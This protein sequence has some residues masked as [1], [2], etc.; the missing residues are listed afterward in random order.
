MIA[1]SAFINSFYVGINIESIL[2]GESSDAY[3]EVAQTHRSARAGIELLLYFKTIRILLSNRG[4]HKKL[5]LFYALFS[6]MM[7]FLITVW[8]ATQAL[9]GQNM[10]LDPDFPGGPDAYWRANIGVWYMG[11]G[12]VAVIVL[13]LM[14]D[15][16]MV[17]H[18]RGC[19]NYAH[20]VCS[21]STAVGLYGIAIVSLSYSSFCGWLPLV[22]IIYTLLPCG[23][24][25]F[26]PCPSFGS[27]SR[28][29]HQFTRW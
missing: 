13:Q 8:V 26:I 28:M 3:H 29:G 1:P 22:S 12:M 7:V 6:S 17:R 20:L 15:A 4:T 18:A 11:W 14:T 27:A 19:Q 2:Y 9:F 5:N 16:L 25:D 10:W 24:F 23:R 21:R